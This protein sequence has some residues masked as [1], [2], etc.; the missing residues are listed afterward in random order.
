VYGIV[1]S[2]YCP[3]ET[4]IMLYKTT[5]ELKLK[6]KKIKKKIKKE[7]ISAPCASIFILILL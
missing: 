5:P 3:P 7:K 4:N 1:E 2:L 6:L